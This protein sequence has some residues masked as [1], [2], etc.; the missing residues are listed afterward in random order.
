MAAI[1]LAERR[2]VPDFLIRLGIRQL[3][4]K[5]L[6]SE[7]S[8]GGEQNGVG[9]DGFLD[10][11]T[12]S[13]ITVETDAAN[14]QHYE[15]PAPFFELVLGRHL[16][17]SCGY[18]PRRETTL[19]ASEEAMLELTCRRAEVEN[20]ME[21]LDLGCGWGSAA[22]WIAER[23]PQSQVLAVSNSAS[24]RE[25]ILDRARGRGLDN[26]DVVTCDVARFDTERRFDRVISVEMFEHVRNYQLLMGNIAK[27][28]RPSGKLFVHIFCHHQLAYAFETE[29]AANWMGRHFFTG[30]IMPSQDLLLHFQ[31]ELQLRDRWR[32]SGLHY[33]R[34]CEAWLQRLD[35]QREQVAS[36]LGRNST[37]DT[38]DKQIQRWRMFFMACAELFR[39]GRGDEWFVTH[40]LF[41]RV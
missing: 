28:L 16:K 38:V 11:L 33:A 6:K 32:V 23:Y 24:Q 13:P 2:L 22:L 41:D 9:N 34:T 31:D 18:W 27:W 19:D 21:I 4:R 3:L 36:A 37:S 17:Y 7:L 40:Y 5:R 39:Y 10:R 20:G 12:Q 15:V 8:V 29:G 14:E 30:G 25:F 26:V 1:R 35:E